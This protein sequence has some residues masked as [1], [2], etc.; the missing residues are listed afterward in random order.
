MNTVYSSSD[1]VYP[2]VLPW[3]DIIKDLKGAGLSAKGTADLVGC[4][5][6]TFQRWYCDGVEPRH[7]YAT[8][9]LAL[10]TRY[11]GDDLSKKRMSEA[12]PKCEV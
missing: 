9:I 4:S 10:H 6:S 2:T 11:C 8:A 5:W 1:Y 7:S 12:T 3:R